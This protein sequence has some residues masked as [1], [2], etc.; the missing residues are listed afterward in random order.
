MQ[1][2][3]HYNLRS[4]HT[5]H[6]DVL[7][8]DFIV[9]ESEEEIREFVRDLPARTLF[10]GGGSNVLFLKDYQGTVVRIANRGIRMMQEDGDEVLVS[11]A[12]GEEWDGFVEFCAERG[13][14][15][16]ENL[17][18][19][20]GTVGSSPIQNIGAYGTELKEHFHSLHAIDLDTC[21]DLILT[22]DQCR[23]GYRDSIFK[24]EL[25]GRAIITEVTFRLKKKAEPNLSY[26][27]LANKFRDVPVEEIGLQKIREAVLE[28]RNSKL[29]DPQLL[30]NAGSFFKNPVVGQ[31]KIEELKEKFPGIVY[32]ESQSARKAGGPGDRGTGG[33]GDKG[34]KGP[35][36]RGTR[37]QGDQETGG[38]GDDMTAD[39][40]LSTADWKLAAGWLI[41]QCG[42]KGYREGDAGVHKDQALVL[43][44]YGAATGQ[45]IFDLSEKIRVSVQEKFGVALERE[46][47]II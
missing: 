15:G 38:Q 25:K 16:L 6:I 23:F 17:S 7:A 20:P 31:D 29:P 45:E 14:G 40:R 22:A 4:Q 43:V 9:L 37:R 13:W 2:Y 1:K 33:P 26:Q 47:N 36:D 46:V 5:F 10:L 12:A 35:R 44:N 8:D 3:R 21:S 42:W 30:G 19:I 32:F 34:T 41:E 11:A 27:A 39:C 24:R 28:I 18:G